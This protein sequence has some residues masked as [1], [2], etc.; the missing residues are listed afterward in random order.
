MATHLVFLPGESQGQRN[1]LGCRL[2][3]L[4]ELDTTEVTQQ[5]HNKINKLIKKRN[6]LF[7]VHFFNRKKV[8]EACELNVVLWVYIALK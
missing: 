8:G 4:T 6:K 1:L 3:D 7:N 5:W 2:W